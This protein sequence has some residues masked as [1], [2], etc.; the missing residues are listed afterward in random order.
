MRAIVIAAGQGTRLRPHTADR[1]KCMVEV[2][3]K[4]MLHHQ[5]DAFERAGIDDVVVIGG[6]KKRGIDAPGARVVA[7]T[8]YA[9]NNILQSLFC[10]GPHLVGD[11]IVSYG[12]IVYAPEIVEALVESHAPGTL[13]VDR[14]WRATYEDRTDHPI[15]Q[16]EL[17]EISPHGVVTR[18][19]KKV[20]PD[21]AFGEFIG[22]CKLT[23]PLVAKMW[24]LYIEAR[25]AGDE[26]PY[27]DAPSLRKAYLTD[28]LN[29]AANQGE[30]MGVLAIQGEWREID[31]VQDLERARAGLEFLS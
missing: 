15:E 16:A 5:L 17:C 8:E 2:A 12:D 19:G 24:A 13:V 3:G 23:A 10:A 11:V 21:N 6:Y 14:A 20:G 29:H 25:L 31:T 9:S 18:V 22:L 28:I 7:N 26:A 30:L 4:P 1:P 27:G